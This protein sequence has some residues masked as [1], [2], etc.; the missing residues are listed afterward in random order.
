M[1][2]QQAVIKETKHIA[3]GT[4]I[5]AAAMLLIFAV[6]GKFRLNVLLGALYGSFLAIANFFA[7]GMTVQKIAET[8]DP[9]SEE[10][11]KYAKLS[12]QR[13]YTLRVVIGGA[14]LV[15]GVTVFKLNWIACFCPL[16]F[17]QLT[18]TGMNI[19]KRLG[20]VKERDIK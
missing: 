15:L 13:S 5:M 7:L 2:P 19:A 18:I 14:L 8:N 1:K 17:P 4:L 11:K 10:S 20:T 9:E 16:I 12:M 6:V 3:A